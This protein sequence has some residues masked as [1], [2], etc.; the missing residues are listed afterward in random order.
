MIKHV[1]NTLS[2][3][4]CILSISLL[5][6]GKEP[7]I[8]TIV[9]VIAGITDFLDGKIARKY[10]VESALGAKL[11]AIGDSLLFGGA[12]F[13]ILFFADIKFGTGWQLLVKIVPLVIAI[14]YKLA[15][16]AVTHKRFDQWNMMHTKLNKSVFGSLFFVAPVI[17][18][19]GEF[20]FWIVFVVSA[21]MF[22]ACLEETITLFKIDEYDVDY[23]GI[24]TET[25]TK[26]IR[27]AS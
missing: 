20:N 11:E 24:W 7:I 6:L 5:F 3:L 2:G 4:R 23:P 9:Y 16:V 19:M 10:N 12:F 18:F 17:M 13:C 8:F 21:A 14:L 26:K 25:I 27:K 1:P 22:L 15:N